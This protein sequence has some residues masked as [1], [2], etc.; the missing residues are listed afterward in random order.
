MYILVRKDNPLEAHYENNGKV[1]GF[2]DDPVEIRKILEEIGA[3]F[4][5]VKI[6]NY[7]DFKTIEYWKLDLGTFIYNEYE[8]CFFCS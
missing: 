6:I 5:K 7:D 1:V 8:F 2:F 3:K 4:V